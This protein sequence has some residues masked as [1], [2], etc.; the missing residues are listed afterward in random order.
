MLLHHIIPEFPT[1]TAAPAFFPSLMKPLAFSLLTT[2]CLTGL[3]LAQNAAP[4]KPAKAPNAPDATT[5]A[6]V[7]ENKATPAER[8]RVA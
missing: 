4:V 5:G 7:N 6:Q 2:L 1:P 8:I 3:L